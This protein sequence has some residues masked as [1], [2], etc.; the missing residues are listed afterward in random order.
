M[1][2]YRLRFLLQEF[3][4]RGPEVTIGRSPDCHITI[5]DPLV[6]RRHARI[7]IGDEGAT[8][9]D[10]ESRNGVRVNGKRI[11]GA[12]ALADGD[13]VRIGTQELVF[14]IA[15]KDRKRSAKTTGF[16]HVCHACGTPFPEQAPTCPHCGAPRREEDTISGL[17]VEPKRSWTFQLLGEVIERALSQGRAS[18]AERIMR[19]AAREVDERLAAGDRLE[20][21]QVTLITGFALRLAGLLGGAEWVHWALNVHR[22]QDRFPALPILDRLEELDL[23]ELPDAARAVAEFAEWVEGAR[24]ELETGDAELARLVALAQP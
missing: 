9:E 5:E 7:V 16:M 20:D 6:S 11:Q 17:L 22:E 13:R 10:F 1:T 21:E 3:D 2:R 23:P 4:L 12:H 15:Q 14:N 19:R 8:V 18:E 24:A